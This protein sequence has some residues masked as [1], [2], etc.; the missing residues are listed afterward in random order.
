MFVPG[1]VDRDKFFFTTHREKEVPEK[2]PFGF[3]DSVFHTVGVEVSS[4]VNYIPPRETH[5]NEFNSG[6]VRTDVEMATILEKE[7]KKQLQDAVERNVVWDADGSAL[8]IKKP[9]SRRRAGQRMSS[10][11]P[12]G[13]RKKQGDLHIFEDN[14]PQGT[15][16]G[17]LSQTIEDNSGLQIDE[18]DYSPCDQTQAM[19][20]SPAPQSNRDGVPLPMT[21]DIATAQPARPVSLEPTN[22]ANIDAT[23]SSPSPSQVQTNRDKPGSNMPM[24][25]PPTI[26]PQLKGH[27]S[28]R[29]R[30]TSINPEQREVVQDDLL[31]CICGDAE[32]DGGR[33]YCDAGCGKGYHIWCIGYNSCDDPRLPDNFECYRCMLA[34]SKYGLL[35]RGER[36]LS[37]AGLKRLALTRRAL[38]VI[39]DEGPPE[40]DIQ[41]GKRLGCE[42]A[43]AAQ[44]TKGLIN[45][46]F[47]ALEHTVTDELGFV[48]TRTT[49]PVTRQATQKQNRPKRGRPKNPKLVVIKTN[50]TNR[51]MERYF[52]PGN[53]LERSVIFKKKAIRNQSP[54]T[55]PTPLPATN[56]EEKYAASTICDSPSRLLHFSST[57]NHASSSRS[58]PMEHD[59]N[60]SATNAPAPPSSG[61]NEA[62]LQKNL[63]KTSDKRAAVIAK[64]KRKISSTDSRAAESPV[65]KKVKLSMAAKPMDLEEE[66]VC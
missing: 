66:E 44:I 41:F 38:K 10:K 9:S 27:V 23:P 20:C 33:I 40:G 63:D 3:M 19:E 47:L 43:V 21:D 4:V 7:T 8:N 60:P 32:D 53:S 58:L 11:A 2:V 22:N 45:E 17:D 18:M 52:K 34:S 65:L 50:A 29:P 39:M 30:K 24:D 36:E 28:V 62:N 37:L 1:D 25:T 51:L 5:N 14:H 15:F 12:I 13:V 55:L 16:W 46:G 64:T 57:S 42:M 26:Q 49:A 59:D 61:P 56:E 31:D 6:K 35:T 48:E 54:V